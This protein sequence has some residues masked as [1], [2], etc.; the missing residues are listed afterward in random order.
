MH[1]LQGFQGHAIKLVILKNGFIHVC[2]LGLSCIGIFQFLDYWIH[3]PKGDF[4]SQWGDAIPNF[5]SLFYSRTE[6]I[7]PSEMRK[8]C[9]QRIGFQIGMWSFHFLFVCFSLR[10]PLPHLHT[11]THT[12][13]P[14]QMCCF[15]P[16]KVSGAY[17]TSSHS[18]TFGPIPTLHPKVPLAQG[19]QIYL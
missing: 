2:I 9:V 4:E 11:H 19:N 17:I 8:R 3:E 12:S 10:C 15:Q 14:S 1:G 6:W 16:V 5:S 7:L 18:H 13:Y